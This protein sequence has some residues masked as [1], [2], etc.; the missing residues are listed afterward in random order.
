MV[1]ILFHQLGFP[2]IICCTGELCKTPL[3]I[4]PE[5]MNFASPD[6]LIEALKRSLGRN[7]E[8]SS[9]LGLSRGSPKSPV[10]ERI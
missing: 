8:R 9:Y 3:F 2:A 1:L 10:F 7:F 5:K 4:P 6:L